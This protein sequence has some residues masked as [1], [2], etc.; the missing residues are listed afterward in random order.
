[1]TRD[2]QH[3]I[4]KGD[5]L[6]GFDF[7]EPPLTRGGT[8]VFGQVVPVLPPCTELPSGRRDDDDPASLALASSLSDWSLRRDAFSSERPAPGEV[9]CAR[10]ARLLEHWR[11]A[12][13]RVTCQSRW[14]PFGGHDRR[15]SSGDG[16][17]PDCQGNLYS[18]QTGL[19][20]RAMTICYGTVLCVPTPD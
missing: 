1:M 13:H 7:I 5:V 4:L 9:I 15:E 2:R 6:G 19:L 16:F 12:R 20:F 10:Q 17:R 14:P 11:Y 3:V 8:G 18:S